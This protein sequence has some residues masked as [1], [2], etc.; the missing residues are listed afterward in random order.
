MK[1]FVEKEQKILEIKFQGTVEQLLKQIN[2]N[3]ETVIV[4]KLN[5]ILTI[6]EILQDADEIRLLSV[7][8]GG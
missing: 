4:T 1:V 7:I 3:S 2:I 8:S 5:E 6:D